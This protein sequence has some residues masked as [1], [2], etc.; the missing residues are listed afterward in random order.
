MAALK[1]KLKVKPKVKSL[2]ASQYQ[3]QPQNNTLEKAIISLFLILILLA[4]II[5]FKAPEENTEQLTGKALSSIQLEK[6]QYN[7]SER[8][9]GNI[10]L[11]VD[12]E[13]IL[14]AATKIDIFVSANLPNCS[15]HYICPDNSLVAWHNYSDGTCNLIDADPE[16]TCCLKAGANCKQ[17]ILNSKFNAA[18]FP[19]WF[20]FA[21]NIDMGN[22]GIES[23]VVNTTG[24]VLFE[25]ALFLDSTISSETNSNI[26]VVQAL[27]TRAFKV[28][29]LTKPTQY[30]TI[31]GRDNIKVKY[32]TISGA[33]WTT[34][35]EGNAL[36]FNLNS[37]ESK[38]V[39]GPITITNKYTIESWIYP[40]K[41]RSPDQ[42]ST[43][44]AQNN[45]YGFFLKGNKLSFFHWGGDTLIGKTS[46]NIN[47]W[48]HVVLTS[49]GTHMAL[50]LNGTP[51]N[52]T[53]F[54]S[55]PI[56]WSIIGN[57]LILEY[58][59]G[60][61]DEVRIYT[62]AL[63]ADEVTARYNGIDIR[64]G[65]VAEFKFD[66]N[67]GTKTAWGNSNVS[68]FNASMIVDNVDV[69]NQATFA[70]A[71][72]PVKGILANITSNGK[73]KF[74]PTVAGRTTL[75]VIGTYND[76][77][78]T[79]SK[80]ICIYFDSPD[81]CATAPSG[82]AAVTLSN[83]PNLPK[84]EN[85]K[86][87]LPELYFQTEKQ[88]KW[89]VALDPATT[90]GT[91]YAFEIIVKGK[92]SQNAERALHYWYNL[93]GGAASACPYG[94]ACV[95]KTVPPADKVLNDGA[96]LFDDW[97]QHGGSPEDTITEI[98]L[99]SH[100]KI[101]NYN[102]YGQRVYFDNVELWK[103][104]SQEPSTACS[105]K[106]HCCA[107]GAG[108]GKYYGEQ[109]TCPQDQECWENCTANATLEL[110]NFISQSETQKW[111][112]TEGYCQ[113]SV[114]GQIIQ[115]YDACYGNNAG[116]T[117]C[118]DTSSN[119]CN[120]ALCK[121]R[122]WNNIYTVRLNKTIFGNFKAPT[123]NGTYSLTVRVRY[124]PVQVPVNE[125]LIH[126]V[127][128]PFYVGVA[129]APTDCNDTF[130]NCTDAPV[131][132][133]WSS[134]IGGIQTRIVNCTYIGTAS[135][136]QFKAITQTQSCAAALPCSEN[137]YSCSEWQPLPCRPQATQ[138]RQ[139]DLM[140]TTCNTS[141][142]YSTIPSAQRTC[143]ISII[144]EYVQTRAQQG[145][146]RA[147]MKQQLQQFGWTGADLDMI[148]NSV[149]VI[150]EK[151]AIGWLVY[152]VISVVIAAI[153]VVVIIFVII[154]SAKK[155]AGAQAKAEAYPEL[156][157]YIRDALTTGATKQEIVAK[158][159]EAGWPKEAIE[160][161]FRAAMT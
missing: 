16:G 52:F 118:L 75:T 81:E 32:G 105:R 33:N 128:T 66:E 63:S 23:Q 53:S 132:S 100:G 127:S 41:F 119:S 80:S 146:S 138:T 120:T 113:A 89:S 154:P 139:C 124:K 71:Q 143:D 144:T 98:W 130:Y 155:G 114:E 28:K 7:A 4:V 62:R 87:K 117:A 65:L 59:N 115:L 147:E 56:N 27:G 156:T 160:A 74:T 49:N 21:S 60:T 12:V 88:L 79:A 107:T 50:Y 40:L 39:F 3:N 29:E 90:P 136:P 142:P 57:D 44:V 151:P 145:A 84:E 137:D 10:S 17:V 19:G 134:C 26:S 96:N 8:L 76:R 77:I 31:T 51:D 25:N 149:Y 70:W 109:L 78:A 101:D 86:E 1:K 36:Q 37:N 58:F 47:Q 97:T 46:L 61:I 161:A 152:V 85:K 45:R 153:A 6:I 104:G 30:V 92:T 73:S 48:Y 133:N 158:L 34:G 13:D 126:Q 123:Q 54:S 91:G 42:Y 135:C 15:T 103:Y 67:N 94:D 159:Q 141:D 111:N 9:K 35:K 72:S 140:S 129:G 106:G 69:T 83:L 14:P 18:L 102:Y 43:I 38:V 93:G 122:D 2:G 11:Q 108:F 112:R 82:D 99:V 150:E 68:I 131:I 116:Y 64:N 22:A 95:N 55:L 148:L 157:S 110:G 125:T 121:C 24:D 5:L 20:T